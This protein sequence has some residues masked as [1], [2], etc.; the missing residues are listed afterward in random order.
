MA[1]TEAKIS[2]DRKILILG[3]DIKLH[4]TPDYSYGLTINFEGETK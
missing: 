3:T 1:D 2:E 4:A